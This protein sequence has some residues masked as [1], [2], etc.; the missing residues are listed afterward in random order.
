MDYIASQIVLDSYC[1]QDIKAQNPIA[2]QAISGL[3]N[4]L[5][6]YGAGCLKDPNT[7]IYCT[8]PNLFSTLMQVTPLLLPIQQIPPMRRVIFYLLLVCYLVPGQV[9]PLA[10]GNYS[11]FITNLHRM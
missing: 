5:L 6:Y 11:T 4:Y 1:G 10:P 7:G 2:L 9:V 3:Q 8:I